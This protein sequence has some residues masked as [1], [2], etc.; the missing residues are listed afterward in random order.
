VLAGYV[1]AFAF[2]LIWYA[3]VCLPGALLVLYPWKLT[4]RRKPSLSKHLIQSALI[5]VAFAP[6]VFGHGVIL[7]AAVGLFIDLPNVPMEAALSMLFT[8]VISF[9]VLTI[10]AL[11]RPQS[12]N[13]QVAPD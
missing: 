11:S 6:V 4:R 10:V 5:T 3:V 2:L 7:P 8:F 12:A 1:F 13:A 9:V